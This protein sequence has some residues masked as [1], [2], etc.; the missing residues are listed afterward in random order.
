MLASKK[1]K[2]IYC[3]ALLIHL[4]YSKKA[5]RTHQQTIEILHCSLRVCGNYRLSENQS[6]GKYFKKNKKNNNGKVVVNCSGIK[7]TFNVLVRTSNICCVI[8]CIA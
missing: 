3:D 8:L 4:A 5:H 6:Q 7:E 1:M 2:L